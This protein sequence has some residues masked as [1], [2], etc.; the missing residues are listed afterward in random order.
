MA[1]KSIAQ[2]NEAEKVYPDDLF[3][4]NQ[5]G[6]AK[7][8]SGNTLKNWLLEIAN[9]LGG[10]SKIEKVSTSGLKESALARAVFCVSPPES[11]HAFFFLKSVSPS[12]FIRAIT[13]LSDSMV[14]N[15]L[16]FSG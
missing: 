7:K 14:L 15:F 10:I 11:F 4:L 13:R 12:S 6:S 5:S 9:S 3:V 8:L 1:D 2:L 16:S